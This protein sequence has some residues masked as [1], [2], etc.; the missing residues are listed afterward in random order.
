MPFLKAMHTAFVFYEFP[1]F[2][3]LTI[4]C[5][6][7]GIVFAKHTASVE[8][9]ETYETKLLL[10]MY[11]VNPNKSILVYRAVGWL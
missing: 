1:S 9:P 7:H 3:F 10:A 5:S 4:L 11:S 6:P 2:H 8:R